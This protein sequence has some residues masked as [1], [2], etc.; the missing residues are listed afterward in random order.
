MVSEGWCTRQA[1]TG[2]ASAGRLYLHCLDQ[3]LNIEK[4]NVHLINLRKTETLGD[5][6]S[7]EGLAGEMLDSVRVL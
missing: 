3:I 2:C 5:R 6:D 4:V 7:C 1:S